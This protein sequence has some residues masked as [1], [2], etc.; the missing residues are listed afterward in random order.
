VRPQLDEGAIA[1][2]EVVDVQQGAATDS[3]GIAEGAL[4]AHQA[5]G[6]PVGEWPQ[7]DAVDEAEDGRGRADAQRQ[8]KHDDSGKGWLAPE[9]SQTF[10]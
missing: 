8:R 9:D 2:A 1:T 6:L 7:Q 4:D 5:P 10:A 3:A